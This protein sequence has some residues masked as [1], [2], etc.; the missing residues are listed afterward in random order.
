MEA[1]MNRTTGR[2]IGAAGVAVGVVAGLALSQTGRTARK[3]AMALTGDWEKQLKSEHRAL[4][5][6]LKAMADS[7]LG[8]A[9]R[10]V[11]LLASADQMITRHSLEEEKVIYPA[12]KAAGAVGA[13]EQLFA[14]HAEMK[15]I[16]RALQELSAEEPAWLDG[17]GLLRALVQRHV[18]AE[19][20]LFPLLHQLADRDRNRT[21]TTLMRREGVRV[22]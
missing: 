6:A 10:R 9:V 3:A 15:T 22:S 19:E 18:K 16:V 7:D 5:K 4:K 1:S 11:S 8:D 12:L 14:D 20:D 17:A 2:L 13:V 21:L